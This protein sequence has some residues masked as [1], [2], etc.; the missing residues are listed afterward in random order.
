MSEVRSLEKRDESEMLSVKQLNAIELILSGKNDRK[1]AERVGVSI[2]AINHWRNHDAAFSA[3]LKRRW[4]SLSLAIHE[5][6]FSLD[7]EAFVVLEYALEG[8]IWGL[9]LR[10]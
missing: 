5:K 1:V 10:C 2:E 3:E 7:W 9:Q 6:M 4:H 8:K